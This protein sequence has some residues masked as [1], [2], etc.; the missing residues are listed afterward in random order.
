V[1]RDPDDVAAYAESLAKVTIGGPRRLSGRIEIRDY[2]PTWPDLYARE[3]RRIRH[4]LGDR[5][6]RLEHVGSTSVPGLAA[7]PVIDLVL[8]VPDSSHEP[9]YVPELE[10][11]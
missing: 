5:V 11:A 7:K 8:E 2:D 4:A 6:R 3:A 10:A 9:A 1:L